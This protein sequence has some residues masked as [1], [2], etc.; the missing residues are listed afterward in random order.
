MVDRGMSKGGRQS[1]KDLFF[2]DLQKAKKKVDAVWKVADESIDGYRE[3][4]CLLVKSASPLIVFGSRELGPIGTG[5]RRDARD[6]THSLTSTPRQSS[7]CIN[8]NP[9]SMFLFLFFSHGVGNDLMGSQK[10]K[11]RYHFVLTCSNGRIPNAPAPPTS[12]SLQTGIPS[13]EL[14]ASKHQTEQR[15]FS[16]DQQLGMNSLR[17]CPTRTLENEWRSLRKAGW[18]DV[19]GARAE[20]FESAGTWKQPRPGWTV[21]SGRKQQPLAFFP[22]PCSTLDETACLG[23]GTIPT[24][25]GRVVVT[26]GLGL[27]CWCWSWVC[28]LLASPGLKISSFLA[29]SRGLGFTITL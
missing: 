6:S 16:S 20:G 2:D 4:N 21:A 25:K 13:L 10:T 17:L 8:E 14:G 27:G 24:Q 29:T 5:P 7:T 11:G 12:S 18:V 15:S 23:V 22:R 1:T 26:G 28:L 3:S 19:V 9:N